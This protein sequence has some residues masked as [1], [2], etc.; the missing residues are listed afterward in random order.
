MK[1]TENDPDT[2][3]AAARTGTAMNTRTTAIAA[4]IKA[5]DKK[6]M[7]RPT[8]KARSG[9]VKKGV[10]RAPNNGPTGR[11]HAAAGP[12]PAWSNESKLHANDVETVGIVSALRRGECVIAR[13]SNF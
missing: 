7:T 12:A 10:F 11:P 4:Q 13:N 1:P 9:A 6:R 2:V 8:S 3:G 5:A